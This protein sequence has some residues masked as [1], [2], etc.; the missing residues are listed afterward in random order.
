MAGAAGDVELLDTKK[1]VSAVFFNPTDPILE[2]PVIDRIQN[3]DQKTTT[4]LHFNPSSSILHHASST[5]KPHDQTITTMKFSE[6]GNH[7]LLYMQQEEDG[8]I[9]LPSSSVAVS[10]KQQQPAGV[11][12]R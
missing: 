1:R 2:L 9:V 11:I 6:M 7:G 5:D 4:T 3:L 10:E 8:H 12:K